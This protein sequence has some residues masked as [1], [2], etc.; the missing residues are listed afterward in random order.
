MAAAGRDGPAPALPAIELAHLSCS[1][2][3]T[4]VLDDISLN[5]PAGS[6]LLLCGANG[7]GA[8]WFAR[9]ERCS[10]WPLA[11]ADTCKSPTLSEDRGGVGCGEREGTQQ[12]ELVWRRE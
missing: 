8:T 11:T 10:S 5:L 3:G 9:P 4:K 1:M 7:A 2:Q 6:R 12:D